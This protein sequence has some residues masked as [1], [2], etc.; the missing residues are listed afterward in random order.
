LEACGALIGR[1]ETI[2]RLTRSLV[3]DDSLIKAELG[4]KPM[5]S[6]A[7]GLAD[8]IRWYESLE[9]GAD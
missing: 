1:A 3:L 6:F 9:A 7:Q 8:T 2:K 4:W 5:I